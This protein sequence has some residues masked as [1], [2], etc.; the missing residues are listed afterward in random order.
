MTN[1]LIYK[2]IDELIPYENNPRVN[3]KAVDGVANSIKEFGFKVPIIIDNANVIVAGHTR[4]KAAKK[5]GITDIP[6]IVA[7][8]LSEDQVKAFRLADNKVSELSEW[9][10]NKL[11]AE[12]ANIAMDMSDF[13]FDIKPK[14]TENPYTKKVDIPKYEPMEP[15]PP[16]LFELVDLEKVN[17]LKREIESADIPDDVKEFLKCA[18][19]RHA[20]FDYGRIAE[21]YCHADAEIQDLMEK[22]ALVII[23]FNK[24]IEYGYTNLKTKLDD[25]M[26]YDKLGNGGLQ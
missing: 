13:G 7:D 15:E 6:C 16:A 8:D 22:S 17:E 2:N 20:V 14:E 23:D 11:E 24:A 4:L 18:S 10:F 5:L 1:K 9:D 25:L 3:E 26:Y 21:Y 12:L 19:Y